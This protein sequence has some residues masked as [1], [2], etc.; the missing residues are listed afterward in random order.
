MIK[1]VLQEII[2]SLLVYHQNAFI[3]LLIF[4]DL[5]GIFEKEEREKIIETYNMDELRIVLNQAI[6]SEYFPDNHLDFKFYLNRLFQFETI[7]VKFFMKLLFLDDSQFLITELITYLVNDIKEQE[8]YT[9]LILLIRNEIID[10]FLI[11]DN[12]KLDFFFIND[13]CGYSLTEFLEEEDILKIY[14]NP[15][16]HFLKK[17][18]DIINKFISCPC[19]IEDILFSLEEDGIPL[20]FKCMRREEWDVGNILDHFKKMGKKI[21][22]PFLKEVIYSN[23]WYGDVSEEL[24]KIFLD[25]MT[26]EDLEDFI[27][28]NNYEFIENLVEKYENSESHFSNTVYFIA[29]LFYRLGISEEDIVY[30]MLTERMKNT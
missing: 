3:L 14:N 19:E 4:E 13:V 18:D 1:P 22:Q 2:D 6:K 26:K 25:S 28:K 30:D 17:I 10:Y 11:P 20:L 9:E 27:K 24:F 16:S 12:K 29:L 15:N 21:I 8:N 7:G 23:N 5:L